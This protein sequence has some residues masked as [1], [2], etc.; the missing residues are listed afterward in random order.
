MVDHGL[1]LPM[2]TLTSGPW[3]EEGILPALTGVTVLRPGGQTSTVMHSWLAPRPP[4]WL[5]VTQ[6]V[7]F[8]DLLSEFSADL[9][10]SARVTLS[11]TEMAPWMVKVLFLAWMARAA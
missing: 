2:G 1:T 5:L 9:S 3:T 11:R 10:L 7:Y 4:F 8:S 6:T